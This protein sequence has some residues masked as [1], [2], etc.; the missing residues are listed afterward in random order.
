MLQINH[1]YFPVIIFNLLVCLFFPTQ[2]VFNPKR[3]SSETEKCSKSSGFSG[4]TM[5]PVIVWHFCI[6]LEKW[7]EINIILL[8]F[9]SILSTDRTVSRI[10]RDAKLKLGE[11][12]DEV[13][14]RFHCVGNK[15]KTYYDVPRRQTPSSGG[16]RENKHS[17]PAKTSLNKGN[18]FPER[19]S[20]HSPRLRFAPPDRL[21]CREFCQSLPVT[22]AF[23]CR[24]PGRTR[25][26]S[27]LYQIA[28]QKERKWNTNSRPTLKTWPPL[29]DI[30][31][32]MSDPDAA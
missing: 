5:E 2:K 25:E 30:Y 27:Q 9:Y 31:N 8:L 18:P 11:L 20:W 13:S 7:L 10:K 32:L 17:K 14:I 21:I 28:Q 1:H 22:L 29:C 4:W 16:F 23:N 15:I 6:L 19:T 24:P 26:Q 3:F 12:E